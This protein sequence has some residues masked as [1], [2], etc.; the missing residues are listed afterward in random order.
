M[1][2]IKFYGGLV[3]NEIAGEDYVGNKRR[4]KNDALNELID[5]VIVDCILT[6]DKMLWDFYGEKNPDWQ[7]RVEIHMEARTR[8]KKYLK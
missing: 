1:N 6:I 5:G 8:I 2:A 4:E 3:M 7:R